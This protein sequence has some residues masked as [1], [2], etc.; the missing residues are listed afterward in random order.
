MPSK[1]EVRKREAEARA[2]RRASATGSLALVS[3]I[4]LTFVPKTPAILWPALLAMVCLLIYGAFQ[5]PWIREAK[6]QF[7]KVVR[8][9]IGVTC[10]IGV[11]SVYGAIVWPP[12]HRHTLSKDE[13]AKFE[14]PLM[15]LKQPKMVIHLYCAPA[16]EADCEYAGELI[17]LFGEAGW[18]VANIV[19]RV[20][21]SRPRPGILIG[22]HGTVKPEDEPKMK[23]NEGEWSRITPQRTAVRQAFLSIGIEPDSSGG[24]I[25]PENQINIF[26]GH[27]REDE[28]APTSMTREYEY[29][30]RNRREHP[31]IDK[32]LARP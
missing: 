3:S 11:V 7:T 23:W 16:D 15:D 26:V 12:H 18:D 24:A 8:A 30:E 14:K 6:P 4:A 1:S 5:L 2:K 31:E 27:E 19:E 17:P 10:A 13:R 20:S 21:L 22:T 28:S 32:M 25:I 9:S 29:L